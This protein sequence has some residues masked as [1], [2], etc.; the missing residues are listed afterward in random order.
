[1]G[2]GKTKK[3]GELTMPPEKELNEL[4][5]KVLDHLLT[6]PNVK[7]RLIESQTIEQK[8]KIVQ[9]H[10]SSLEQETT[11]GPKEN[12]LLMHILSSP[13]PDVQ[14]LQQLRVILASANRAFMKKFLEADGVA[15]IL[16]VILHRVSRKKL[17]DLDIA[18]LYEVMMC[19]KLVMN[20]ALGMD[21]FLA[22]SGSMDAIALCLKFEYKYLAILVLEILSACCY[23]EWSTDLVMSGLRLYSRNHQE[24]PFSSL[25]KGLAEEDIEVK[26]MVM[27]FFNSLILGSD[28]ESHLVLRGDLNSQNFTDVLKKAIGECE[29]ELGIGPKSKGLNEKQT[30]GRVLKMPSTDS[31]HAR[32]LEKHRKVSNLILDKTTFFEEK[33]RARPT[34]LALTSRAEPPPSKH[35]HMAFATKHK[36][37]IGKRLVVS[38][39]WVQLTGEQIKWAD[40]GVVKNRDSFIPSPPEHYDSVQSV[41]S[42]TEIWN[43]S[44]DRAMLKAIEK[45]NY[46]AF[47]LHFADGS[48][49]SL[50]CDSEAE[51]DGWIE[52]IKHSK[53]DYVLSRSSYKLQVRELTPPEKKKLLQ[54]LKKLAA[55]YIAIQEEEKKYTLESVGVDVTDID[56]VINFLRAETHASGLSAKLLEVLQ[57]LLLVP[58]GSEVM[59]D[60]VYKGIRKLRVLNQQNHA[61]AVDVA[62]D[63]GS[64]LAALKNKKEEGGAAYSQVTKLALATET[65]KSEVKHMKEKM[66]ELEQAKIELEKLQDVKA[67]AASA[68]LEE[69]LQKL[70]NKANRLE[71]THEDDQKRISVLEDEVARL[72]AGG[73]VLSSV[74]PPAGGNSAPAE[75]IP[76]PRFEKFI[77]MKKM[78]PEGAVRQKMSLEGFTEAEVDSFI[79]NGPPMITPAGSGGG[80]GAPT[81]DPRFEKFVKMKKMLPEGAVRQK[82]SLEGFT[83][84]EIDGFIANGPPMITPAG[85]G[86]GGAAAEPTPDPR[87]EKFVK[88]KKMLPEGA[89]RQKMS[90]EGFTEAE[91]DGFIK[92]G[93]PMITPAGDG[94]GGGA[95]VPDPRFE[96]FVKMKKMLPEGAVRQKMSLEGFTEA[97]IDGFIKDGPP[98]ISSG[99]GGGGAAGGAA[100]PDPRFEKFIKMKKMLPEGAVRQKMSLEGFTEAEIDGFMKDGPPMIT[101]GGGGGGAAPAKDPRYEKFEKMKKMLP[102]GAVRQKMSLDGFSEQE[103]DCFIKGLPPPLSPALLKPAAARPQED[104]KYE[105]YT[106]MLKMLPEGAVRQKMTQDGISASE[107]DIFFG[108]GPKAGSVKGARDVITGNLAQQAA[109]KVN[110]KKPTIPQETPPEGMKPKPLLELPVKLKTFFWTKMKASEVKGTVWQ[111]LEDFHLPQE[112]LRMLEDW[113]AAK[114]TTPLPTAAEIAAKEK[115][116][117]TPKKIAVLDSKRTQNVLI[118]M[119][120]L[121]KSPE[122]IMNMVIDL[123]VDVMTPELTQ[124]IQTVLPN[125]EESV[126]IKQHTDPS[127]LDN[128]S[129]LIFHLNRIPKVVIRV[130]CHET[131]FSWPGNANA[132]QSSL[133][134]LQAA[135]DELKKADKPIARLMALILSVG[136]YLNGGSKHGQ[137]YGVKFETFNKLTTVKA[138]V[139]SKGTLMNF[140]GHMAEKYAPGLLNLS[141]D[142]TS[143]WAAAEISLKQLNTEINQLGSQVNKLNNVFVGIKDTK[144][145]IGLDGKLEDAKGHCTNPLWKRLDGFLN[146]A[147]PRLGKIKAQYSSIEAELAVVMAKY[148]EKMTM[149][150]EED[151]SMKFFSSV[152]TFVRNYRA[153]IDENVKKRLAAEKKARLAEA[154]NARLEE[155]KNKQKQSK[156]PAVKPVI[157]RR[158]DKGGLEKIS[159]SDNAFGKLEA[160]QNDDTDVILEKFRKKLQQ[161]QAQ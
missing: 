31:E 115:A 143:I 65:A 68:Q 87:F 156:E 20:N 95:P 75:P 27:T 104:P 142:W 145:N 72:R 56:T 122:D 55:E 10:V 90:L 116:D 133:D 150:A 28:L 40:L 60:A 53:N 102:E 113:F 25:T 14:I 149:T 148:G 51:K 119:G 12:A 109:A 136:N 88:M 92:D 89:V 107:I 58:A 54:R 98:M 100:V 78:L 21:A 161:Q 24:A 126:A 154:A 120:K 157:G 101:S 106:K 128:A 15:I 64:Y 117:K 39:K 4:Y 6:P 108:V 34:S 110:A 144:E 158:G 130:D 50:G 131:A 47:E 18:A 43:Y 77:K 9:V 147:K 38:R 44:S 11:W 138:G 73:A 7:V 49:I 79:T 121:R 96:K 97:E 112:A 42:I 118:I 30:S 62:F 26:V 155:K 74:A 81:P 129:Q 160:S 67:G 16:K 152:A 91:I 1:M 153:S 123:D 32:E 103:I 23:C 45:F 59:W 46:H 124:S 137:A 125:D 151:S 114:A 76:D 37:C 71:K 63:T 48:A 33:S 159:A 57:E 94:G 52:A 80:G 70:T 132:A 141:D 61:S 105:K 82:M 69:E 19:C 140:V 127:L 139:P 36:A 35:G 22:V 41:A 85:G 86:G 84:A 3:N 66:Q 83:E 93:P 29:D 111:G 8:W 134:V 13:S 99:G 5:G 17:N 146:V 2:K 135:I